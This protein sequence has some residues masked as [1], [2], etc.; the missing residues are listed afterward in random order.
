M[1]GYV[2][3]PPSPTSDSAEIFSVIELKEKK[4][5]DWVSSKSALSLGCLISAFLHTKLTQDILKHNHMNYL[6][7]SEWLAFRIHRASCSILSEFW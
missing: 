5:T 6:S 1:D 7:H 2:A 3:F 4:V